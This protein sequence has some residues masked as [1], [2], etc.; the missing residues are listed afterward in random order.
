MFTRI[1]LV[2]IIPFAYIAMLSIAFAGF[3]L[4][5]H[6]L[7]SISIAFS[8]SGAVICVVAILLMLCSVRNISAFKKG[9]VGDIELTMMRVNTGMEKLTVSDAEF[10]WKKNNA[11]DDVV[12]G[13]HFSHLLN[14]AIIM[15]LGT[16][17]WGFGDV[18]FVAIKALLSQP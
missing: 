4:E 11:I 13:Y 8:R 12:G 16:L 6:Q 14:E 5:Y 3:Y 1:P 2:Y 10:Y 7:T 9:L 18:L 15:A 17:L